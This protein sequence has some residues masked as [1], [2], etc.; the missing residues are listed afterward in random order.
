MHGRLLTLS[1][2]IQL[3]IIA[4]S[5]VT[6]AALHLKAILLELAAHLFVNAD[7]NT[8][9]AQWYLTDYLRYY[10]LVWQ[11]KNCLDLQYQSNYI[12]ELVLSLFTLRSIRFNFDIFPIS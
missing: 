9:G 8:A 12:L 11:Q 3:K 7:R 10:S 6:T 2:R 5:G 4:N 1:L